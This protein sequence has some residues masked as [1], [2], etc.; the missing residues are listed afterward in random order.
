MFVQLCKLFFLFFWIGMDFL[1]CLFGT[2][3]RKDKRM[4]VNCQLKQQSTWY[5]SEW[6]IISWTSFWRLFSRKFLCKNRKYNVFRANNSENPYNLRHYL[7]VQSV[8]FFEK[9]KKSV[10]SVYFIYPVFREIDIKLIKFIQIY[11]YK[12]CITIVGLNRSYSA[13]KQPIWKQRY[14]RET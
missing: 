12:F 13:N 11:L 8:Q 3:F 14:P 10:Q 4:N 1:I 7:Y 6:K 5:N 9:N 2:F